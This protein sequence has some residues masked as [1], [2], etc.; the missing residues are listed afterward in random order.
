MRA[1]SSKGSVNEKQLL[2][3]TT[4]LQSILSCG[5]RTAVKI[6]T[7]AGARVQNGRRVLWNTKKLQQY[8]DAISE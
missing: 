3:D 1:T 2:V 8:L 5:Y 4:G 7:D 6:G